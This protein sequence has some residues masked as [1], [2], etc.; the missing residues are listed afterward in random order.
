MIELKQ[1]NKTCQFTLGVDKYTP[2]VVIR[3]CMGWKTASDCRYIDM[4]GLLKRLLNMN[5]KRF[6]TRVFIWDWEMK[7]KYMELCGK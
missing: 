3:E 1:F 5:N 4:S 6:T 2:N 7:M